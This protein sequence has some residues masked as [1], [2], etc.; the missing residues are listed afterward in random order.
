MGQGAQVARSGSLLVHR[1]RRRA[2]PVSGSR[3]TLPVGVQHCRPGII[4]IPTNGILPS[5]PE[6]VQ[7][8]AESCPSSRLIINLSLDGIGE[9]HDIIRG[10]A[11]NFEKFEHTC[12]ALLESAG[13]A[14]QSLRG[15]P[16]RHIGVQRR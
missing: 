2:I 12:K 9:K 5:I 8:I 15:H 1:Q 3:A 10:V 13:K 4:N 16:Y 7:R 6:Q 14:D 11:G